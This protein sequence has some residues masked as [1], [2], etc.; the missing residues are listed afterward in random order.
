MWK[1][2]IKHSLFNTLQKSM[3][4]TKALEMLSSDF[5]DA[6][7][8]DAPVTSCAATTK[9]EPPALDSAPLKVVEK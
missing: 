5:S 8:P 7:K 1:M 4:E 9:L 3:D 6:P 2:T